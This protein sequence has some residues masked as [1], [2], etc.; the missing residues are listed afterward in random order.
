MDGMRMVMGMGIGV[1]WYGVEWSG[2]DGGHWHTRRN[3]RQANFC[4]VV[5]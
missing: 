5:R 3:P 2:L 1:K 4:C